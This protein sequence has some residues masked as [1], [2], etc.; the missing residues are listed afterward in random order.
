MSSHPCCFVPPGAAIGLKCQGMA[1]RQLRAGEQAL[2]EQ[3]VTPAQRLAAH[4][5]FST[6]A[7]QPAFGNNQTFF[8]IHLLPAAGLLQCL[9]L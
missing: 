5:S 8:S 4:G 3:F 9:R 7:E 1:C 6:E 2:K